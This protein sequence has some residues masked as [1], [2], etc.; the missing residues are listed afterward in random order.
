MDSVPAS[1]VT[2][3]VD[4]PGNEPALMTVDVQP[5]RDTN[6]RANLAMA[7]AALALAL[8]GQ[9]YFKN[10]K[11]ILDGFV[12]FGAAMI[13]FVIL[14]S[15][16]ERSIAADQQAAGWWER[17]LERMRSEPIRVAL[18]ALSFVLVFT[19]FRLLKA[20]PPP[21][22]YWD[23]FYVW[24]A[25]ISCFVAAFVHRPRV[26]LLAWW[27][28]YRWELLGVIALTAIAAALRFVE[29]GKVPN[30]VSGDEGR[31][32]LLALSALHGEINNMMATTFG[33]STLYLF[34]IAAL[35]KLSDIGPYGLRLTSAI[36]GALS[37]PALYV[38][39]RHMFNVR[40]A[41]VAAALLTVSHLHLHFSRIVVAGGIQDAL[42]ATIAFY[43][44]LTGLEKRS[45]LRLVLSA[46]VIGSHIYIYMGA[47]LVI[48]FI[49]VYIL[50]LLLV[51]PKTVKENALNLVAF[52][53]MLAML[54][55]PM[56]VWALDHP[57]DFMARANQVG[58]FQSG[59]LASE[60][61]KLNQTQQHILLNL[62]LQAFLTVNYY[63]A[64]GFYNSPLPMLDFLSGAV[65]M[66]GIA[67]SL[68][69]VFDRRHL[70]LQGWFWSGVVVGGAL[71]VLPAIA[72]YRILIVFPAVC[73]F[74]GLGLDRLIEFALPSRTALNRLL[75]VGLTIA[76]IA[77]VSAS[78]V[79]AYFVDYGPSCLYED[80][81]TRFASYM[82]EALGKAGPSY[83]AYLF[84][85]PRIWYGI[86]P[87]VD[88]LSGRIPITDIKE[89]L[90][91]P[92][93][94]LKP[95]QN[96]IFF[97]TPDREKELTFVQ[98]AHP[99]GQVRQIYDCKQLMLTIYQVVGTGS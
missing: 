81:G 16:R 4:R 25:G 48:L 60:A 18:I 73:I 43:F 70:L 74:V 46:L 91:A 23:I 72:A 58:V 64:T 36:A 83:K 84:G 31:I 27:R 35:M 59:W 56:G 79:R 6:S 53:V 85:Y 99:G 92:A 75:K 78:N 33:H 98:Q 30:I 67:Y 89:P 86:H 20:Q 94:L 39:T 71:V 88:Y 24:V 29:L 65:F 96:G 12:F 63:P 9:F 42:F 3:Q 15:S 13:L 17:I 68:Y 50:A 45:A 69:H 77:V 61:I 19:A 57:A 2:D 26:D 7:L 80:W 40:T 44:L 49:P 5:A 93:N 22:S 47:R 82:G 37:V 52:A 1:P 34:I 14:A 38:L 87:S 97:F 32:G 66:L 11:S 55:V 54:I 21:Q 41:F 10:L 95:D 62:L 76:F 90:N 28:A 8:I 51:E